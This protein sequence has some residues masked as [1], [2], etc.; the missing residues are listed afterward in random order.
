MFLFFRSMR[1][2]HRVDC[3][4]ME[5]LYDILGCSEDATLEVIKQKYQKLALTYHPDKNLDTTCSDKFVQIKKAWEILSDEKLRQEY[6]IRWQQRKVAQSYPIQN[7]VN[8]EEFDEEE[9]ECCMTHPCRCGGFY[10]LT[11]NDVKF[12][13]DIVCCDTCTLSIKIIYSDQT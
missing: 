2:C 5:N 11:E 6:N 12:H 7:E 1:L 8:I 13:Y 9:S 4:K 10:V 3:M